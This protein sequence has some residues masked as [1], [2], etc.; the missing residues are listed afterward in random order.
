[1]MA[2]YTLV[3]SEIEQSSI[4]DEETVK[5][6]KNRREDMLSGKERV[7][8]LEQMKESLNNHRTRNGL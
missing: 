5:M 6:L 7:L 3:S 1:V 4:Y 8:T 2:I